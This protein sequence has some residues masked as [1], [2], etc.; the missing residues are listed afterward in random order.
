LTLRERGRSGASPILRH[1]DYDQ[2]SVFAP[3]NLLRE[4]R[5]QKGLPARTVPGI[6]VLDPDGD[7]VRS[8][9]SVN[10]AILD[11]HWA[12]Y[13][14]QLYTFDHDGMHFGIIGSVVGA[15]FAVLVAEE[16]F[17]CGCEVVIS[18]TSSGLITR[19][20]TPPFFVLIERALRDEGT[21]Y[22]YLAPSVYVSAD[23]RVLT[24][25]DGAFAEL[26]VPVCRGATWTTDAPFRETPLA[27]EYARS[28]GIIAVEMEA[29]GLYA[30]AQARQRP[31]ICFAHVTNRLGHGVGDFEKGDE[32]GSRDALQVIAATARAWMRRLDL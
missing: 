17:A 7:I 10:Q 19:N 30:L 11:A 24:I 13:H 5:R 15:P 16:L 29:A 12:C 21:S 25:L 8:L 23:N 31:I 9:L 32:W 26:H 6:C 20:Q 1:K 18:V 2:P 28:E 27:I 4:A 14:S 3:E 22:H